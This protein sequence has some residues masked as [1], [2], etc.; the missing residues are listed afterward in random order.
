MKIKEEKFCPHCKEIVQTIEHA[1]LECKAA[2]KIWTN[3][4]KWLQLHIDNTIK[5]IQI[6][7]NIW[8]K[9]T[10]KTLYRQNNDSN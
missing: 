6:L 3:V 7:T 1:F 10:Q 2:K 8:Q 9:N 4:G 5:K